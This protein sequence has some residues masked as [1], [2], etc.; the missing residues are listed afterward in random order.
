MINLF[1]LIKGR[2]KL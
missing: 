1:Y 2:C